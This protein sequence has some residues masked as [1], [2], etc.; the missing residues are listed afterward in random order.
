MPVHVPSAFR[1][2]LEHVSLLVA[3]SKTQVRSTVESGP[4]GN[5]VTVENVEAKFLQDRLELSRTDGAEGDAARHEEVSVGITIAKAVNR[6]E[7]P[8]SVIG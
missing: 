5:E 7:R 8:I 6:A 1:V 3:R 4:S 2:E